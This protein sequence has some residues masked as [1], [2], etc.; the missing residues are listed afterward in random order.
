MPIFGSIFEHLVID[1]EADRVGVQVLLRISIVVEAL[2]GQIGAALNQVDVIGEFGNII[3]IK[4]VTLV[5]AI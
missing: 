5:C 4:S 1:G 2:A 3:K